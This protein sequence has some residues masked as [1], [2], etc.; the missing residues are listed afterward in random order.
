MVKVIS[1]STQLAKNLEKAIQDL[2]NKSAKIGW[3][4]GTKYEDGT[5][6]AY[7]ATIQEYGYPPKNIPPRSFLR[8]TVIN[9]KNEWTGLIKSGVKSILKG[10]ESAESILDEVGARA[11]G[12][13]RKTIKSIWMPSLKEKT[14]LARLNRKRNKKVNINFYNHLHYVYQI[15]L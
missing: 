5:R 2:E 10:N 9:K 15:F 3:F 1:H 8:P 7:V 6:V 13:I 12:D 11:A 4:E 14:I